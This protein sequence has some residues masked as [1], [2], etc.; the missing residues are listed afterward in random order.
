MGSI[1]FIYLAKSSVL[2]LVG[3]GEADVSDDDEEELLGEG[4]ASEESELFS[5]LGEGEVAATVTDEHPASALT[6]RIPRPASTLRREAMRWVG[7]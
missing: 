3:D 2:S 7:W 6:P 1:V 4:E 5:S